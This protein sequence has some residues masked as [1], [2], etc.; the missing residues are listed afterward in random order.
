MTTYSAKPETVKRD[1][2]IV[3]ASGKVLGRLASEIARRLKGKHKPEFTTHVD[4]G[5]YVIVVNAE[6][7]VVTGKK[8]KDKLYHHLHR[9]SERSQGGEFRRAAQARLGPGHRRGRARHVAE[10]SA[11]AGDVPQAQGI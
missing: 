8:T 2:Y 1:W 6:K 3:D 9:L 11:G 10:E 7:I 4:T 5:D